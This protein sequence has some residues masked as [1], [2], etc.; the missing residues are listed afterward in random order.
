VKIEVRKIEQVRTTACW[1]S[2]GASVVCGT[3]S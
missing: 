3:D 2:I 1:Q